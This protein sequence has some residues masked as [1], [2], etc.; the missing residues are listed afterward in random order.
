[1]SDNVIDDPQ[2]LVIIDGY[3]GYKEFWDEE[4]Y[5]LNCFPNNECVF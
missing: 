4:C 3:C 1:M 5:V 2:M